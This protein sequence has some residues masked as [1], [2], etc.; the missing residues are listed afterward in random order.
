MFLF[1]SEFNIKLFM[2]LSL[3]NLYIQTLTYILQNVIEIIP[4]M[5]VPCCALHKN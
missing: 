5:F 1:S 3:K 2:L 4:I